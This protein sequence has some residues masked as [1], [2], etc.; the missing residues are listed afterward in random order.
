MIKY[1]CNTG[2]I[3]KLFMHCLTA[4][5]RYDKCHFRGLPKGLKILRY[6]QIT[7]RPCEYRRH[8]ECS[9]GSN[10]EQK[11]NGVD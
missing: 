5:Y 8:P 6:A 2:F 7:S 10:S 9:E 1:Y 3:L 4:F 11:Y